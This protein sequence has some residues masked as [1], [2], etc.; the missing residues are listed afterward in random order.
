MT[1]NYGKN[2]LIKEEAI[3]LKYRK[4]EIDVVIEFLEDS[5]LDKE[6]LI[7]LTNILHDELTYIND[8]MNELKHQLE[9]G[10]L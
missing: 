3:D 9:K 7:R 2:D 8:E 10:E 6:V 1:I 4:V 5:N